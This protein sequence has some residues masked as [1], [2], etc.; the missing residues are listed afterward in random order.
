MFSFQN[1]LINASKHFQKT[2]SF[3]TKFSL[4]SPKVCVVGS[5][6]AGFSVTQS[7]LRYHD[8][9]VVDMYE[10]L[11][12]PFGLVRSGVSPDHQ[13]VKNC[14]NG[15]NKTASSSRFSYYGNVEVG[16]DVSVSTLCKNYHVVVLCHGFQGERKLN[17]PGEHFQNVFT[18]NQFVGWYNG[19]SEYQDLFVDLSGKTAVVVGIG[20]VALDCARMLLKPVADLETTDMTSY[21][22][23]SLKK[24]SVKNIHVVGR[25][26]PL[27]MACT[28]RELSEICDLPD[29]DT[30][31]DTTYFTKSLKL[32][33]AKR[34][35]E[36]RR[37]QRLVKYLMK[38][39]NS[40]NKQDK[41]FHVQL[42]LRPVEILSNDN[43]K[44]SGIKLQKILMCDEKDVYNPTFIPI[45]EYVTI[46]CELVISCI[47]YNKSLLNSSL[48]QYEN[49]VIK[50]KSGVIDKKSGLYICGWGSSG[51]LGV[52]A[53][54]SNS[55]YKIA[56]IILSHIDSLVSIKGYCEGSEKIISKLDKEFVSW[57]GWKKIDKF[58][59]NLGESMGK[60]R[61][62]VINLD[63]MVS[64]SCS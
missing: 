29:V 55:A 2:V 8:N 10:K 41:Q 7:L 4:S 19:V 34:N 52:L 32:A 24:S 38:I 37:F 30:H 25:R 17:I 45:D 43:C 50:N 9:V 44:V 59:C 6:P 39:A 31:T 62:K 15:Y 60:I 14:I 64:I 42:L 51:P 57:N 35:L 56:E 5:G 12:I 46:D 63:K 40:S 3:S 36:K 18:S 48:I 27:Q 61:E 11:P 33:L 23:E 28:R 13:D 53:D 1:L 47:G 22:V 16:K 21:A 20:N 58:E 49:G 54:T 26:G